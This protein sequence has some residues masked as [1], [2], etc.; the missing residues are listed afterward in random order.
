MVDFQKS[1]VSI[2]YLPGYILFIQV[3]RPVAVDYRNLGKR[4]KQR[5]EAC[6]MSQAELGARV[7][8]S[9]QHIS[10]VENARS[11]IGLEK[12]VEI[13]NALECSLDELVCGSIKTGKTV[14][15]SEIAEKIEDFSDTELRMLPELLKQYSYMYR[16]I[17]SNIKN[18]E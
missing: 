17:E 10:N 1:I 8:L 4:I 3:V 18:E 15:V 16:F 12:L 7:Q 11:R 6:K 13:A 9:T 5:R 14:Y 2:Q